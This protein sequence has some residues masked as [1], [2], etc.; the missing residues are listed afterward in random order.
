[1]LHR[2]GRCGMLFSLALSYERA[3]WKKI[4]ELA[5]GLGI[6]TNLLTSL[7]FSCM[8]EVNRI[9]QDITRQEP[10]QNEAVSAAPASEAPGQEEQA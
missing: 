6:P 1:L 8:E 10:S 7:Y 2:T 3:D 4:D 9:W 5:N